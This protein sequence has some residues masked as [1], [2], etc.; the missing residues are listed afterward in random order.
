[1]CKYLYICVDTCFETHAKNSIHTSQTRMKIK[2]EEKQKKI[3]VASISFDRHVDFR[4]RMNSIYLISVR[5]LLFFCFAIK[6]S[7]H[8]RE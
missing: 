3:N 1:M 7:A 4:A 2:T 8:G 6:T 5:L